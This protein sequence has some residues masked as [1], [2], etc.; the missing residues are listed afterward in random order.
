[1][2]STTAL[3]QQSP[4]TLTSAWLAGILRTGRISQPTLV[5]STAPAASSRRDPMTSQHPLRD[6]AIV[7]LLG[8][9][10]PWLA[11]QIAQALA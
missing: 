11:E 10:A 6:I 3:P 9:F 7:M 5:V 4:A 2:Q 8:A 1:M